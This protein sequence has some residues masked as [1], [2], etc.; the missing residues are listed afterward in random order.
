MLWPLNIN[1]LVSDSV[2][3]HAFNS[4]VNT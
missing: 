2:R 4:S 3:C 1:I